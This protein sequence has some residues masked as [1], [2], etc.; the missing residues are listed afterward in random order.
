MIKLKSIISIAIIILAVGLF[1]TNQIGF[2][3]DANTVLLLHMDGANNSTSFTDSSDNTHSVTAYGNA[4]MSTSPK[5]FGT[6]SASFDGS[7]DYLAVP[8][9]A[10]LNFGSGNFTLDTLTCP[11]SL[12][13]L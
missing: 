4:K 1:F 6:A 10:D 7:G 3:Q 9:S 2:A 12:Y 5:K 13:H 11:R 8:D